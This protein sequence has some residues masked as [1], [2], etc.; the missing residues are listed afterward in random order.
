M[1][2]IAPDPGITLNWPA[3]SSEHILFSLYKDLHKRGYYITRGLKFGGEYLLYPGEP[4]RYHSNYVVSLIDNKSTVSPR[5]LIALG[6]LGTA[7]KKT[8][9]LC[10]WDEQESKFIYVTLNWSAFG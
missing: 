3:T 10:S 7:V 8:R 5:E 1:G 4:M 6:R 9:I 2:V